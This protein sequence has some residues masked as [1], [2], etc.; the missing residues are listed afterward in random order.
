[1]KLDKFITCIFDK[2]VERLLWKEFISIK[3]QGRLQAFSGGFTFPSG[4]QL[5]SQ[6]GLLPELAGINFDVVDVYSYSFPLGHHRINH[7]EAGKRL[8]EAAKGCLKIIRPG[9]VNASGPKQID[10]FITMDP[11]VIAD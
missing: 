2:I 10:K 3:I 11:L 9:V 4:Q 6:N 1:M 5:Y 8:S 7:P